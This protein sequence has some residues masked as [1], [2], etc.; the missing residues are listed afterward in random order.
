MPRPPCRSKHHRPD[1]AIDPDQLS[2]HAIATPSVADL[3]NDGHLEV[4]VASFQGTVYV[5]N[6]D[7]TPYVL[8]VASSLDEIHAVLHEGKSAREGMK[9]LLSRDPR[10]ETE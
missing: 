10:P 1:R 6:R 9:A 7:G 4:V 8:Q 2:E 5:F 3:D